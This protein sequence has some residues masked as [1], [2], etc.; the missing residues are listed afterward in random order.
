M[1]QPC[2][3]PDRVAA[4]QKKLAAMAAAAR[5]QAFSMR[6]IGWRTWW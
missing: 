4:D 1:E 5:R 2:F 3:T 6:C